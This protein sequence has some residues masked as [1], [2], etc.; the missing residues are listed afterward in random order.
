MP[1]SDQQLL[2]RYVREQ[3]SLS[4]AGELGRGPKI[5][6]RER[7]ELDKITGRLDKRGISTEGVEFTDFA[8]DFDVNRAGGLFQDIR[9]KPGARRSA[10]LK[11]VNRTAQQKKTDESQQFYD[12]EVD[13]ELQ[14]LQD[15]LSEVMGSAAITGQE[16]Q[17]L[18]SRATSQI[19][20]A[21]GQRLRRVGA[22]LGMRGLD[23]SSPAGALLAA[24]AADQADSAITDTLSQFDLQVK[25]MNRSALERQI[26]LANN[27]V[28]SR[29]AAKN[30]ALNGDFQALLSI[31]NEIS[32]L[33]EAVRQQHELTQLQ[34]DLR[35][36]AEGNARDVMRD[37][38]LYNLG[39]KA[40][41]GGVNAA[42]GGAG[43]FAG[44]FTGL[45]GG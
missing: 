10:F 25:E 45:G 5:L 1:K 32:G 38:F 23:P 34:E 3:E 7:K 24:Q 44:G 35:R 36:T 15:T 12:E 2:D 8:E 28:Q 41:S 43:G 26:G 31:N 13:P 33:M 42:T 30:A 37:S 19:R 39:G 4:L 21:E 11:D 6:N 17:A 16:I 40:I 9:R 29:I 18:K 27:L 20:A 22:S 14:G